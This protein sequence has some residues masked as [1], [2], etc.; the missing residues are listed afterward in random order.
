M[1][2]IFISHIHEDKLAADALLAFLRVKLKVPPEDMFLSSNKSIQLGGEW[3]T[4]IASTFQACVVVVAM[5]SP[6]ASRRNWVHF[7]AGGAFFSPNKSLIPLCIGGL[8]PCDLGRPYSNILTANLHEFATAEHL[9][10]SI[11]KALH[12]ET[13]EL[14][15]L[16][17]MPDDPDVRKLLAGLDVWQTARRERVHA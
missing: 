12:P 13:A 11:W 1:P 10:T 15:S 6:E 5:F 9:V 16:E 8:D 3:L 7:E 2:K 4:L 14:P 17:Y